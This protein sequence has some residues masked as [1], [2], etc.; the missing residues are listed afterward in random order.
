MSYS[1]Q[2]NMPVS[3]FFLMQDSRSSNLSIPSQY[4]YP[5]HRSAQDD[6]NLK[7]CQNVQ[8]YNLYQPDSTSSTRYHTM[9]IPRDLSNQSHDSQNLSYSSQ[10]YM[11][12]SPFF[13]VQDSRSSNLLSSRS[14]FTLIVNLLKMIGTP[15]LVKT[16]RNIVFISLAPHLR[17]NITRCQFREII[18]INLTAHKILD[19]S[20]ASLPP[21][22]LSRGKC[23]RPRRALMHTI[24]IETMA[25]QSSS[26]QSNAHRA[27]ARGILSRPVL[28]LKH[29]AETDLERER[30][31]WWMD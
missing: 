9:S 29:Q 22:C 4:P 21:L 6:R 16:F 31:V 2:R 11:P 26:H 12:V 20:Q 28:S 14:I 5:N 23:T 30:R 13:L 19:T 15:E 1:S 8:K 27:K 24:A 17:I 18:A 10:R 25:I 7:N 3:P